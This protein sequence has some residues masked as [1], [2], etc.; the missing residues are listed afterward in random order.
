MNF[1]DADFD[2]MR[3]YS[4]HNC[5]DWLEFPQRKFIPSSEKL[6]KHKLKAI[7]LFVYTFDKGS[8]LVPK[9]RKIEQRMRFAAGL[10]GFDMSADTKIIEQY[11]RYTQPA[12]VHIILDILKAQSNLLWVEIALRQR[13]FNESTKMLWEFTTADNDKDLYASLEKKKKLLIALRENREELDA[14]YDEFF[15]NDK[16]L[17]EQYSKVAA[18]KVEDVVKKRKIK[19]R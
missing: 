16:N 9:Y 19:K 5:K 2:N 18:L 10:A 7:K 12:F 14:M 4:I 6:K 15:S 13:S 8:P 3:F 17:R 1:K 11:I